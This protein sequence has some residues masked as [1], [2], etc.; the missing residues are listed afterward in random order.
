VDNIWWEA[1]GKALLTFTAN[2]RGIIHKFI[3]NKLPCNKTEN[4]YYQYR[5]AECYLCKNIIENQTHVIRCT[6][7]E[8]RTKLRKNY[9]QAIRNH[10]ESTGTNTT[11]IRCIMF[12]L[13]AWLCNINPPAIT[14]IAPDAS[15]NLIKAIEHQNAI[16]WDQWV[17]GRISIYWG[18]L[19]NYD[20]KYSRELPLQ[21]NQ[22][23]TTTTSWGKTINIITWNFL[24]E[25][26]LFRNKMEHQSEIDPTNRKK[27]K[28]IEK[29]MWLKSMITHEQITK[30]YNLTPEIMITY[31]VN[32]LAMISENLSDIVDTK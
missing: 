2:Q 3:H 6:S 27:E 21:N 15:N 26:W 7:C 17:Y 25:I 9:I 23:K 24:I 28:M 5:P 30:Y 10:L 12:Y 20:R 19:Y 8:G 18:E 1:H 22:K 11:T 4:L 29:I 13:N 16:G 32:N 31:P 14:E